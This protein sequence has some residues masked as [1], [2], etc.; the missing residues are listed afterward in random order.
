M[1]PERL[2]RLLLQH[3]DRYA[4][5]YP[6]Q[7]NSDHGPMALLA[8]WGLGMPVD[9]LARF[10]RQYGGKLVSPEP[11][12]ATADSPHP[13]RTSVYRDL[14][15]RFDAD[16]ARDG[17][18]DTVTRCLPPLLSGCAKDAFHPLIRL[19]YGVRFALP[20]EVAAGLAY[21]TL[22]GA[23]AALERRARTTPSRLGGADYLAHWRMYRDDAYAQGRFGTR[24]ARVLAQV[25]LCPARAP[26]RDPWRDI[27]E[28]CLQVF[29]ATH[30]FF[31]LHMV[32]AS[33]ALRVCA[34]YAGT[35][36]T[37]I[38]TVALATAYLAIGAPA[39]ADVGLPQ[40]G[41]AAPPLRHDSD[42][43]DIKISFSGME[44][45]RAFDDARYVAVATSYRATRE[46]R[47]RAS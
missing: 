42:E 45:A 14:L 2:T 33:H 23:D 18:P 26:D 8:M 13:A 39:C 41:P 24:V 29:H 9:D 1:V 37:A 15:A 25:P 34:P 46:G 21:L 3:R 32:T 19:A 28:A 10:E 20:S 30:D 6:P 17:W 35:Q 43:H 38:G 31:A 12:P 44:Q 40:S 36:V 47:S 27:S 11:S 22:V 5:V 16:I 4:P 7:D